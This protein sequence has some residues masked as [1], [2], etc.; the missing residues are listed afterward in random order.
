MSIDYLKSLNTNGSGLNLSEI[1][2]SLVDAEIV[3][4]Q[5]RVEE[6]MSKTEASISGLGALRQQL[7]NLESAMNVA[8]QAKALQASSNDTAVDVPVTNDALLTEQKTEL[9]VFQVAQGQVLDFK[10]LSSG[11]DVVTAGSLQIDFGVWHGDTE[12]QSF[13]VNPDKTGVTLDIEAG[14]TMD[15]VAKQLNELEGISA[16]IIRIGDGTFSLG[17]VTDDG[18]A[19]AVRVTATSSGVPAAGELDLSILDNTTTNTTKQIQQATDAMLSVDGITVFRPTNEI[20]DIL[21]GMTLNL[22]NATDYPVDVSVSKDSAAAK[23]TMNALLGHLNDTVKLLGVLTARGV[24][25]AEAGPLAGDPTAVALQ[26][27]IKNAMSEGIVG[28][29]SSPIYLSELGVRTERDGTFTLDEG[30]FDK[31]FDANP[32][33]YEAVFGSSIRAD[34][35][36]ISV[37]RIPTNGSVA[38]QYA[39]SR[40]PNTG[41]ALLG[42]YPMT[43]ISAEN[44]ATIFAVSSGPMSGLRLSVEDGV[45]SATISNGESFLSK[46]QETLDDVLSYSGSLTRRENQL[47]DKISEYT[48]QMS[49]LNDLSDKL[50]QRYIEKF[51]AMET[52]ITKMK[53]TGQYLSNLMA[54]WNKDS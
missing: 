25:G 32:L 27:H 38:G 52:M 51:S 49:E 41:T 5:A 14:T 10:G 6:N 45:N 50:Q 18:A 9:T 44:G 13:T 34:V 31:L 11:A 24:D 53:S 2:N 8:S 16:R 47:N 46:M 39:F 29:T 17:I 1:T 15:E 20:D 35:D 23:D 48:T 37:D 36:G 30:A 19:N 42:G 28:F 26:R 43:E 54:Q 12:P 21:P 4:K 33:T 22:N 3:P 7:G 40:D